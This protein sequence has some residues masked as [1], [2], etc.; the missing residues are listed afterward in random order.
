AAAS[1]QAERTRLIL[2][3]LGE[4]WAGAW[5]FSLLALAGGS[6]IALQ[7]DRASLITVTG[8]DGAVE[9]GLLL[10]SLLVLTLALRAMPVLGTA[11]LS[12]AADWAPTLLGSNRG[13]PIPFVGILRFIVF[14]GAATVA[15]ALAFDG[16]YR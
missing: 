15:L 11:P 6:A 5:A 3:L 12:V 14:A 7:L 8:W 4:G 9:T 10:Q 16:R 13:L 2:P 1:A